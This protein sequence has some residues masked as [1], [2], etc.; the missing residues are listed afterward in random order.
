VLVVAVLV[1]VTTF[2]PDDPQPIHV[3]PDN[4]AMDTVISFF[5]TARSLTEGLTRLGGRVGSVA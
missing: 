1:T 4:T 2:V 3:S 5:T